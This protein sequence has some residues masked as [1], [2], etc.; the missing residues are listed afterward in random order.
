M[1]FPPK[2]YLHLFKGKI[3]TWN[4]VE[5]L[6][7]LHPK[8]WKQE[9]QWM[10][11]TVCLPVINTRSSFGP[12]QTFTL[13]LQKRKNPKKTTKRMGMELKQPSTSRHEDC[14]KKQKGN[15]LLRWESFWVH[16]KCALD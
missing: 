10:S 14:K 1:D 16:T 3:E 9:Q 5:K 6:T 2:T 12:K 15:C 13:Y 11:F 4:E 7:Y 8:T